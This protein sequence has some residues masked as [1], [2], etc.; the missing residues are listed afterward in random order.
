MPGLDSI[1]KSLLNFVFVGIGIKQTVARLEREYGL[2]CKN[3]VELGELA[4]SVMQMPQLAACGVDF[5][6]LMVD[7]V[8]LDKPTSVV[9]SDWGKDNLN[10]KQIKFAAA[11]V[12]AYFKIGS[13]LLSG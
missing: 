11:N 5:L 8:K 6:A 13:K 10:K 4:A 12:F 7:S 9:F 3:V 1:P 2:S